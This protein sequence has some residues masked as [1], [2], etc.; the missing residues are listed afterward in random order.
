VAHEKNLAFV[1]RMYA[2]VCRAR[3][4]ALLVI[5]GEGPARASLAGLARE[6]GITNRVLFVGN[7]DREWGLNDCYA[8][9][10][11]FVF[12]SRT[13]TQGLVLL[14]AMAQAR[15]VVSTAC[16]G[17]RSVVTRGSGAVV[18]DEDETAFASAVLGVLKNRD[19]A[20][21]MGVKG[22]VWAQQ[23]SSRALAARMAE[24]YRNLP[25]ANSLV[26]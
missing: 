13:E 16:L 3:Q 8:A 20:A 26:H 15:P 5:A 24:L 25:A 1:L 18:V 2:R 10:D 19:L 23:W 11:V 21:Q 12:A 6:M 7:L 4:D 14:E 22:R 17:T 9:A